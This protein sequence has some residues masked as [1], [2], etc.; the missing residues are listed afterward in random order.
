MYNLTLPHKMRFYE[1]FTE[2]PF[3]FYTV[4]RLCFFGGEVTIGEI[5]IHN[6]I[7][8]KGWVFVNDFYPPNLFLK[9][10]LMVCY[11]QISV[12]TKIRIIKA[13]MLL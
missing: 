12:K 11:Q 2:S 9:S 8:S 5:R 1:I 4:V 3:L 13:Q 7:I 6:I 10:A